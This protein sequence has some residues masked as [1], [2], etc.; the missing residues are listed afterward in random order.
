M[1]PQKAVEIQPASPR[2]RRA[3]ADHARLNALLGLA[4]AAGLNLLAQTPVTLR[5]ERGQPV[6]GALLLLRC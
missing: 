4:E 3:A 5:Q 2:P 6:A 1:I